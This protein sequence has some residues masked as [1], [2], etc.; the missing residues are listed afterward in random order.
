MQTPPKKSPTRIMGLSMDD[1]V[2]YKAYAAYDAD[3]GLIVIPRVFQITGAITNW[4]DALIEEIEQKKADN[5]I[6]MVEDKSDLIADAAHKVEL[7][8]VDDL[9]GRIR[10]YIALDHYFSRY[11]MGL[12]T[13]G[14]QAQ[15]FGLHRAN[16]ID[17]EE[18][19]KGRTRYRINQQLFKA[20]HRAVLLCVLAA[21]NPPVGE[22]YISQMVGKPDP[23][24]WH[25]DPVRAFKAIT[26]DRD[27]KKAREWDE[28]D[29]RL[30]DE[31]KAIRA[32]KGEAE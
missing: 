6:I 32:A 30:I 20:G 27:R 13:L 5:W 4:R 9:E 26:I 2:K 28:H 23:P 22:F 24:P 25:F 19:D 1:A 7:D 29:Q 3:I 16:I 10:L 15:R 21:V 18:D 11:N 17:R 12:L 8:D 31:A 14:D